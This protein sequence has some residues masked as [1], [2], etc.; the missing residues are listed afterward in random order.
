MSLLPPPD[1]RAFL[2]TA[3]SIYSQQHKFPQAL[4]LSIRLGDA[5]LVRKDFNAPAN[6]LM[7]RQLAFML[8]RAQ[9]PREWIEPQAEEDGADEGES[10][11][12]E[13]IVECLSNTHLS[14]HFRDFG[15]ELGVLEPKSL[16]DVYKS[17]LENASECLGKC[18][19]VVTSCVSQERPRQRMSTRRGVTWRAPS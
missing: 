1:D 9:I 12:P 10:E 5:E 14:E 8:A 7:K 17:H 6:P 18:I 13:D 11:L 16:E 15:K 19:L 3:H 4:A 2:R